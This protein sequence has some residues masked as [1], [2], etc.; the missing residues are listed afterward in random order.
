MA[1]Y[2]IEND[3]CLGITHSGCAVN[4]E[5]EGYVELSDEEVK[6]LKAKIKK[7]TTLA[8]KYKEKKEKEQKE[9]SKENEETEANKNGAKKRRIE[10]IDFQKTYDDIVGRYGKV[11]AETERKEHIEFIRKFGKEKPQTPLDV[12]LLERGEQ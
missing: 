1:L 2:S 12:P 7:I 5:S 4:V 6:K 10:D 11:R 3:T 8:K 9:N